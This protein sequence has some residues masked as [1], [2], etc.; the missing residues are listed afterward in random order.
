MRVALINMVA[1]GSTGNIM[2][3]IVNCAIAQGHEA[4]AYVP[5]PYS[6]ISKPIPVNQES[7]T[8]FCTPREQKRH[9]YLGRVFGLNGCFSRR[10]TRALI[11]RMQEANVELIHLHNLHNYSIHLPSLFKFIKKENI[12]VVWTLHDC[13]AFTGHCPH[14]DMIGCEKWKTKCHDCPLIHEYPKSEFD[15]SK[16]QYKQKK[17]WFSNVPRMVLVTPSEWLAN[18]VKQSFL[19]NYPVKVINNGI[20]LSV[21]KPTPSDFRTKWNCEDKKIVL[22]V[23]FGWG[24]KKGLDV[25]LELAHRLNQNYQIVLVGT[26]DIVDKTLPSN[27]ISIHRTQNKREL[28]EI[29]SAADVF[30]N[31]TREE[32][33]PTV[34]ME[35]LACGTPVVTYNTGGCPEII[36]ETCGS[37]VEKND[38]DALEKEILRICE[39]EPFSEEACL[40]RAVHFDMNCRF[41]EYVDLYDLI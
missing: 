41:K 34:Q 22:G 39:D 11:K 14:Y 36:D 27:I 13:W 4:T 28:A 30:V 6:R 32:N 8:Y 26:N 5:Y 31:P 17:T 9:Y 21:F 23:A 29:Y 10:G 1:Q 19:N 33:Y 3:G 37:V 40:M 24:R 18:Q 2:L 15:S 7:V 12:K 25:F 16:I 35:A 38:I 20:D